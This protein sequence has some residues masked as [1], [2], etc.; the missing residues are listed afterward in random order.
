MAGCNKILLLSE[1]ALQLNGFVGA[2]CI[3]GLF[4]EGN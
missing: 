3:P 1:S 2:C 4:R